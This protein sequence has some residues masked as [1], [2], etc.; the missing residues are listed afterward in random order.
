MRTRDLLNWLGRDDDDEDVAVVSTDP[1]RPRFQTAAPAAREPDPRA[2]N[3]RRK[4]MAGLAT[5]RGS[6]HDQRRR[7]RRSARVRHRPRRSRRGPHGD[8]PERGGQLVQGADRGRR[9]AD[10]RAAPGV[11]CIIATRPRA[12]PCLPGRRDAGRGLRHESRPHSTDSCSPPPPRS[13]RLRTSTLGRGTTRRPTTR[14]PRCLRSAGTT[15]RR[16]QWPRPS[17]SGA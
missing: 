12:G 5:T 6:A 3:G 8:D 16:R 17:S 4:W 2:D 7:P 11:R 10:G 13:T 14:P 1:R 15:R 9:R